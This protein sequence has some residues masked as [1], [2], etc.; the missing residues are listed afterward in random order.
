MVFSGVYSGVYLDMSLNCHLIYIKRCMSESSRWPYLW[1]VGV[2]SN[3]HRE[4]AHYTHTASLTLKRVSGVL[5]YLRGLLSPSPS[6]A[7]ARSK[8]WQ[9]TTVQKE[10]QTEESDTLHWIC[11]IKQ[12]KKDSRHPVWLS[13]GWNWS[14][15][16]NLPIVCRGDH[17]S[18]DF[19]RPAGV[20]VSHTY[21]RYKRPSPAAKHG[22]IVH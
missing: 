20:T 11:H 3:K 6:R 18:D 19:S 12:I 4:H 10:G 14:L 21:K 22:P 13:S 5:L 16:F 9:R 17:F 8:S 15:S 1:T 7:S 2:N